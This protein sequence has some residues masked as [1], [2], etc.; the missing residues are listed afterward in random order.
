L[1]SEN[2]KN[3]PNRT[4][5]VALIALVL[6]LTIL[7]PIE[8]QP[9]VAQTQFTS[10]DVFRIPELNGNVSFAFDGSYTDAKLE[11]NTW[12]FKGLQ[13]NN[14]AAVQQYGFTNFTDLGT[15][16]VSAKDSNVTVLAFLSF[17]YTIQAEILAL[18]IEGWGTQTVNLGLNATGKRPVAEWSVLTDNG[19]T[20][21]AEGSGWKLL[22]DNSVLITYGAGNVTV[23]HF[24]LTDPSMANLSFLAQHYILIL[25]GVLVAVTVAVAGVISYRRYRKSKSD[26][27]V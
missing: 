9:A 22:D 24:Y 6:A 14:S 2:L 18:Y 10:K 23:A 8:A 15:L 4:A 27:A 7:P 20:F 1:S 13:L 5:V 11:N 25:T 21:L 16:K 19:A 17:N 3:N 26:L 12:I